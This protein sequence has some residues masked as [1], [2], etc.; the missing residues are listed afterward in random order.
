[1]GKYTLT[2]RLSLPVLLLGVMGYLLTSCDNNTANGPEGDMDFNIQIYV[3]DDQGNPLQDLQVSCWN[4]LDITSNSQDSKTPSITIQPSQTV[5]TYDITIGCLAQMYLLDLDG[6]HVATVIDDIQSAGY[7]SVMWNAGSD[8][9]CGV[10]L[11]ILETTDT[12]SDELLFGDTIYPVL[13][14]PDPVLTVV[15][16]TSAEGVLS[17]SDRLLFPNTYELPVIYATD[18]CGT[19]QGLIEFSSDVH[20]VITDTASAEYMT[21]DSAIVLGNNHFTVIWNPSK[22]GKVGISKFRVMSECEKPLEIIK[23]D[24]IIPDEWMLHQNYP[25]P[26]N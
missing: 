23:V 1:M 6:N 9:P 5:I 26:F 14:R 12:L 25:N 4:C 16:Y 17:T 11:C 13:W 15:G 10:Y 3:Q 2:A 21:F 22:H 18:A 19:E 20:F 24:P 8:M 7:Y